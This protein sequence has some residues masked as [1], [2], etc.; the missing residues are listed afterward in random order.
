MM[1]A[2]PAKSPATP[3]K[4]LRALLS[5]VTSLLVLGAI[6]LLIHYFYA[7]TSV[8]MVVLILT[9]MLLGPVNVVEQGLRGVESWLH[10]FPGYERLMGSFVRERLRALAVLVVYLFFAIILVWGG[11]KFLP[12]LGRQFGDMSARIGVQLVEIS[13]RVIDWSDAHV[14]R[15]L[16]RNIFS[17]D[18]QQAERLGQVKQHSP[19]GNPVT[20]E[21]KR[22]IHQSLLNNTVAH[23]ENIAASALPNF[24]NLVG[25]TLNGLLYALV[26]ILLMFYFL[27]DGH[28]IKKK[29]LFLL[30]NSMR[31]TADSLLARFHQVM[32]AFIKGQ[33]MLGI[34]TGA[35]MFVIYTLFHVPYAFLLGCI[36]AVA[37]LLPVVGTWIGIG[38]GLAV[39][40]LNMPPIVAVWVWLCSYAY[41]TIK[42]NILAPKVVGDVMGLHPLV[43]I[44]ALLICAKVAGLLGVLVALPLASAVNVIIRWLLEKEHSGK[45]TLGEPHA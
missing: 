34:L 32:F 6:G 19:D 45:A 21:E 14:R 15:G 31:P 4:A 27:T 43:I 24:I 35:Y 12:L 1:D 44:L 11:G 13:D 5:W 29:W 28:K 9:Y 18:I 3:E 16:F 39:I 30:P 25:G 26:A 22:V 2:T 23:L 41:Q 8:L 17:Q 33:V 20:A 36:F 37:E 42:D 38:I 7:L 40:L 10:R